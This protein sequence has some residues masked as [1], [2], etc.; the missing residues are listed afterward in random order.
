MAQQPPAEIPPPRRD[1]TSQHAR[2]QA[3]RVI[4]DRSPDGIGI[5]ERTTRDLL[6]FLRSYL[7]NLIYYDADNEPAGDWSGL[8][9]D[10]TD[11][12]ILAFIDNPAAA[13]DERLRRPHLVLLLVLFKLLGTARDALNGVV[14]RHLDYYYREVLRLAPRPPVA[15]RVFV[16][17][18]LANGAPAVQIPAGTRLPAGRDASKRERFFRTESDLVVNRARIGAL[19]TV[20][21]DKLLIGLAEAR[22]PRK[23]ALGTK[24]D[25]FLAMLR[26]ALGEPAPGG[27]LPPYAGKPVTYPLLQS[28]AAL[29]A[30]AP[31]T[32]HLQH[33]ELRELIDRKQRRDNAAADWAKINAILQAAGRDAR[34]DPNFVLNPANPRDFKTNL[35]AALNGAPSFAG[36][37]E[38]ATID[39]LYVQ[40]YRQDV[41]DA[42]QQ[43]LHMSV[44]TFVAMMDLKRASDADWR[45]INGLLEHAGQTKRNK[46]D[47]SLPVTDPTD[48]AANMKE[49]IGLIDYTP[50]GTNSID[51]YAAAV[52]NL[53]ASFYMSA[54]AFG[55]MMATAEQPEAGVTENTWRLTYDT[56]EDALRKKVF[57]ARRE[58]LRKMREAAVDPETGLRQILIDA[59]GRS[60]SATAIQLL[61]D[62]KDWVS[63]ADMQVLKAVADAPKTASPN[64][65]VQVYDILER[66]SRKRTQ[67]PDPQPQRQDWLNL[68]AYADAS[69]VHPSAELDTRWKTFGAA[70][71]A[72]S[73]DQAP[74]ETIGVAIGSPLFALSAGTRQ[75]TLVFGFYD[76]GGGAIVVAPEQPFSVQVS[77]AD[78]F[79]TLGADKIEVT[80]D[81]GIDYSKLD[82]IAPIPGTTKLIG[83]RVRLTLPATMPAIAP[84]PAAQA[85]ASCPWPVV[86]LTLRQIWDGTLKRWVIRYARLRSLRLARIHMRAAIG[87]YVLPAPSG[88]PLGPLVLENDLGPLDGKRPFEPFGPQPEAGAMLWVGHPD[89]LNKRLRAARLR[90]D[91]MG[92]PANLK[93]TYKAY[94]LD[95]FTTKVSLIS[96]PSIT[97][98][99]DASALFISDPADRSGRTQDASKPQTLKID[100][101]SDT[102]LPYAVPPAA[103]AS[104][105][106][107]PHALRLELSVGFGHRDYPALAATKAIA[108]A[109]DAAVFAKNG[110]TINAASYAVGLPYTP[111]LK[112]LTLDLLA[113][114]E[115]RIEA[116]QQGPSSD[117]VLHLHPFGTAE[118]SAAASG[119]PLLPDYGNEGELLIGLDGLRPP[120]TLSLLFQMAEGSADADVDHPQIRWSVLD[121]NGWAELPG[122][123]V[124]QDGT[125][126]LINSGIITFALPQA[127]PDARLP[128]GPYWLR[129]SVPVG[130]RAVCDTIAIHP[131]AALATRELAD[132]AAVDL[133]P[134]PPKAIKALFAPLPGVAAVRQPYASFGGRPAEDPAA[135][136]ASSSERL[137][138]KQR[139]VT[140]WDYER[141]VLRRF[142]EIYK[143]KCLPA[144]S[145]EAAI[146]ERDALGLVRLVVIPNIRGKSLFDPFEPKAS[147]ALLAD[148]ADY[149]APLLPGSARLSV[150]NARY[151]Q[152]RIRVGVRFVDQSNPA[153]WK[154]RLG[155]DLNRFLSPWAF[156]DGADIMIGR[157]IY[158]SSI[159]NF[160]DQRAYVDYVAGIKLFSSE[161]GETFTLAAPGRP[162]GDSVGSERPDAVLVA[163]RRHEIDLIADEIYP[164][165]QFKGINYMKVELD[166]IVG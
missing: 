69:I 23:G 56:L 159:V 18:D 55:S 105:R 166:F 38:I 121:Q 146:D 101:I 2:L 100:N 76:D 164:A 142:P 144:T 34:H 50:T 14:P 110:G 61:E 26:L 19:A 78:G 66:A 57:A 99:G 90:L 124:L 70:P 141:L 130:A 111:K 43:K 116:Y 156:D 117:M 148:I 79:V 102:V 106:N 134:L 42:I 126:G 155:D 135:F 131:Q 138:H 143:V 77:T 132:T 158:A 3:A 54:E 125:R 84:L 41:R 37:P 157:R 35:A 104:A 20:F 60:S 94:Q 10:L 65:W 36:L 45:V 165:D 17:F 91:W 109:V 103:A 95:P 44:E 112:S 151:V 46:T 114:H 115:I 147:S 93:E 80:G 51:T 73:P 29:V 31:A 7:E 59:A 163:A 86:R 40:R 28:L 53:E 98:Q 87:S 145:N 22:D 97:P 72:Q 62:L 5:D 6:A 83:L 9:G 21:T 128:L 25:R 127:S 8:L 71:P 154:Q 11:D 85:L 122:E 24:E 81:A 162:D 39:D 30:F 113:G 67:L 63:A 150:E 119:V 33:Y 75:I 64:Q 96:G 4:S 161:D 89:L 27:P 16:L 92:G 160:I 74:P 12:Q 133:T 152:V 1:G 47:Y 136:Y 153:L 32:L 149:L 129:A 15:D 49:A 120:E 108:L 139:A 140:A 68:Y 123:A 58:A 52:R 13:A 82:D 88:E 118:A 137:R 48:F 107:L